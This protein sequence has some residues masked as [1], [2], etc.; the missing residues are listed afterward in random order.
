MKDF[1]IKYYGRMRDYLLEANTEDADVGSIAF[2]VDR[3]KE[4]FYNE[5]DED[6][7]STDSEYEEQ[8]AVWGLFKKF[9]R[10][11]GNDSN[12]VVRDSESL[13]AKKLDLGL[14][15]Y[16]P[17]CPFSEED[18]PKIQ[19]IIINHIIKRAKTAEDENS[20]PLLKGVAQSEL[21]REQMNYIVDKITRISRTLTDYVDNYDDGSWN[22]QIDCRFIAQ[23][24]FEKAA[25]LTYKVA[26]GETPDEP[27]YD[28][29]EAF[30]YFQLS[31]PDNFQMKLD[32]EVDKLDSIVLDITDF[33]EK[34]DYHLCN[35][36][37]WFYPM[38]YN[39][40][41]NGMFYTLEQHACT[42]PLHS[43]MEP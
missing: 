4:E 3:L 16:V 8:N 42:P 6:V 22:W 25:E 39:A 41:L 35:K 18:F 1:V 24:V 40:A 20:K 11:H 21:S 5:T 17:P 10:L 12:F 43:T 7:F 14:G 15:T 32:S 13:L 19:K 29:R 9:D 36:L 2:E 27:E 31:V 30:S 38:F 26:M 37:T 28:I 23:Y 33:I 34:N